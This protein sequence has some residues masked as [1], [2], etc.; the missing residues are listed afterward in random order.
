MS[1]LEQR[2]S[3]HYEAHYR[4]RNRDPH[5]IDPQELEMSAAAHG[6]DS[7]VKELPIGSNVLDVGCGTGILLRWL[8]TQ[9]NIIPIGVDSSGSQI[10]F[11]KKEVADVQF[12]HE[13]G[14]RFLAA[15]P[16]EYDLIF[17]MDVIE[18]IPD[19]ELYQFIRSLHGALRPGGRLFIRTPN[20]AN[21][22]GTYG[23]YTDFTHHRSFTAGS[24]QQLLEA[25]GFADFRVVPLQGTSLSRR[26]KLVVEHILHRVL[27]RLS[28][29]GRE[30]VFTRNLCVVATRR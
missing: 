13:D 19:G 24:A 16:S 12:V 1:E 3:D 6:Y 11:A 28:G 26:A 30:R 29:Y 8:S 27:F 15:H 7:L 17:C 14:L 25:C 22:A 4:R 5:A 9:K 21:L 20:A 2:L 23:R 18:H 10:A